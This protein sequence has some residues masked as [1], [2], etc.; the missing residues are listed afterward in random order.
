MHVRESEDDAGERVVV[1]VKVA[2]S[3]LGEESAERRLA[4]LCSALDKAPASTAVVRRYRLG[5]APLIRDAKRGWRTG[6]ADLVLDGNFDL[7]AQ[8]LA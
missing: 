5:A 6:R 4:A 3:P 2:V 7:L 1:R 8:T